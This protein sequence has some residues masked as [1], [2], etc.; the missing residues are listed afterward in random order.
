MIWKIENIHLRRLSMIFLIPL[1]YIGLAMVIAW[2]AIVDAE[3]HEL[4]NE[5]LKAWKG[6]KRS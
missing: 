3:W 4:K 2:E 6:E 5:V 1:V